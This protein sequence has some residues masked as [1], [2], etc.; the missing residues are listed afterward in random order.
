MP[1]PAAP[2][3]HVPRARATLTPSRSGLLR[4]GRPHQIVAGGMHYFR[5]HPEQWRDRLLRLA[6]LGVNA[7]DTYV[8]W[9]FHE[10]VEGE[11]MFAGWRDLERYVEL[12]AGA[13]LDVVLRPGPYICAEWDNGGLPAW[14]TADADVRLRSADPRFLDP[15]RRWFDVLLPRLVPLQAAYGG[16]IIAVQV[17]NE[18][19]SF[20]SD[21]QY[22][23]ALRD[24]LVDRGI[25]ELLFTADGATDAMQQRGAIP[26]V[27]AA[28]TFGSHPDCASEVMRR[29]RPDDPFVCAEFWNGWFDHWG[30]R[31]HVR[32]ANDAA[33]DIATIVR[34]GGSVSIYMAHG[35]TNFGLWA[36]ANHDGTALQPTVTS[37][38]SDAAIAENGALTPKFDA[39]RTAL[40]PGAS[41][42]G[43]EFD[44]SPE[45]LH[46]RVLPVEHGS[47][48]LD[49]LRR[50]AAARPGGDRESSAPPTFE[51]LG[52]AHGMLLHSTRLEA[53]GQV[54]GLSGLH[55]RATVFLDG[56]VIGVIDRTEGEVLLP[57]RTGGS[58]LELLVENRGRINYGPLLGQGKGILGGVTIEGRPLTGWR[59]TT[60]ELDAWTTEHLAASRRGEPCGDA[61]FAVAHL[62]VEEPRDAFLA[63]PGFGR[64]FVWVGGFLLG[65]YD[66]VGPQHT[67]YAP[68]PLF[69]PGR[70]TITVLELE[71]RGRSIEVR[72]QAD[73]G[74]REEFVETL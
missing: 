28:A 50:A 21:P 73:L 2:T 3:A 57:S 74:V 67:L 4:D 48:L 17:E 23:A 37:Y 8:A 11:P 6:E 66:S 40:W 26:G 31:H 39:I 36:G 58:R 53:S 25:V 72:S 14:L 16:P 59:T 70:N 18:F 10:P 64:G 1:D 47:G 51:Q 7:L 35:G 62:D 45:T 9:N 52:I 63:L 27:L 29:A 15:V 24:L 19:G 42:T 41:Y 69:T 56:A 13:G 12:A 68:A 46:P 43:V 54:L 20:G 22:L 33:D 38:D 49:G 44:A 65:R 71:R 32:S 55:D 60:L 61:G 5:V 34:G 30:E